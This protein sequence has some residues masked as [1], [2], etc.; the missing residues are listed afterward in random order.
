MTETTLNFFD[1]AASIW[2]T[3]PQRVELSRGVGEAI[4]H[5][6]NLTREMDVLDYGCGT[7]LLGLFLLPYVRSVT[8]VDSSPGMLKVLEE[9]IQAGGINGMR[10]QRLDLQQDPLPMERYHLIAAH[11]VMHHVEQID[12]L[13]KSFHEILYPSGCLAISD[14]DTEPGVFHGPDISGS[15]FHHGFDREEFMDQMRQ[16]GFVKIKAVTAHLVYKPIISGEMRE[17]PV[18]LITGRRG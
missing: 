8:G 4:L 14:L 10:T 9:K 6:V 1:Q 5:Q 3:V 12:A 17:F 16:C 11:M 13:L 15:V 18:F 7:G 2:D